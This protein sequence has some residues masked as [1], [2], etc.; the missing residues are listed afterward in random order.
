M[1]F[2][3]RFLNKLINE[4]VIIS[5]PLSE[6][7]IDN[8]KLS[9]VDE[10]SGKISINI[11]DIFKNDAKISSFIRRYD[12]PE[13]RKEKWINFNA[14]SFK[15]IT[16]YMD[17]YKNSIRCIN[18]TNNVSFEFDAFN[19]EPSYY[20]VNI[21]KYI[22]EEERPD[23]RP[24]DDPYAPNPYIFFKPDFSKCNG[25]TVKNFEKYC[26]DTVN[27]I[28]HKI[29]KTINWI[30]VEF[31]LSTSNTVQSF[32]D[33]QTRH[34]CVFKIKDEFVAQLISN[35]ANSNENEKI[36]K[37]INSISDK[38][39]ENIKK[40][41]TSVIEWLLKPSTLNGKFNI[42]FADILVIAK[43]VNINS[44]LTNII[45]KGNF[46]NISP[47]IFN[48][49]FGEAN[50]KSRLGN[51]IK[52]IEFTSKA[53]GDYVVLAKNKLWYISMEHS[54]FDDVSN[55]PYDTNNFTDYIYITP[56]IIKEILKQYDYD[57]KYYLIST[58]PKGSKS[59]L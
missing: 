4:N 52:L 6:K 16:K 19:F 9:I 51:D 33:N 41:Y 39:K 15:N 36:M 45:S 14:F 25:T 59:I 13:A 2:G 48:D 30:E 24:I 50:V 5:K 47:D 57:K 28:K 7:E 42:S 53:S 56:D 21:L 55:Y 34:K 35:N 37:I 8:I 23:K 31:K 18:N 38:D 54:E 11:E 32:K 10:F 46:K 49:E 44:R 27:G 40:S 3:E 22:K 29:E 12:Y 43:L 20:V 17:K 58:P 1:I 26:E